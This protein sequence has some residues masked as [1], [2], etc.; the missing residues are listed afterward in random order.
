M[1]KGFMC[2]DPIG[3]QERR[4]PSNVLCFILSFMFTHTGHR[5]VKNCFVTVLMRSIICLPFH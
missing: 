5:Y 2:Q 3:M 4:V 1:Y